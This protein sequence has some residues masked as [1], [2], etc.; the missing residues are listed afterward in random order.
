VYHQP[1]YGGWGGHHHHGWGRKLMGADNLDRATEVQKVDEAQ[2][3][4]KVEK[5]DEAQKAESA[6]HGG[7]GGGGYGGGWGGM[8]GGHYD[9]GECHGVWLLSQ[10]CGAPSAKSALC[11]AVSHAPPSSC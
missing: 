6:N 5:V 7:W 11:V 8:G 4:N 1:S 2:N 3:I 10:Y 9:L